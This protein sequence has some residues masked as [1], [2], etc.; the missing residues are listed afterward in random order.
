MSPLTEYLILSHQAETAPAHPYRNW[1]YYKSSGSTTNAARQATMAS[2]HGERH[3]H[4]NKPIGTS[5]TRAFV[6]R[7]V[8]LREKAQISPVPVPPTGLRPA[9]TSLRLEIPSG[10]QK[11]LATRNQKPLPGVPG[12]H[13]PVDRYI[14]TDA[15][16]ISSLNLLPR[17]LEIRKKREPMDFTQRLDELT[18]QNGYLLAEVA[19]LKETRDALKEL[20]D[21]TQEAFLVLQAALRE[22]SHRMGNSEQRLRNY[23]GAHSGDG[24]EEVTAF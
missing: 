3:S 20:Q 23:W 7:A 10:H 2:D 14:A 4:R 9:G 17:G 1:L 16:S 6:A 12:D 24:S 22:V 18:Q 11:L 5:K 19:L 8:Q 21:Q 15:S 13:I